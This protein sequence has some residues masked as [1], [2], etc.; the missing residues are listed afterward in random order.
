MSAAQSGSALARVGFGV[1][2]PRSL[3][4]VTQHRRR[5]RD[6]PAPPAESDGE[7]AKR[8]RPG[9]EQIIRFEKKNL[10]QP[11]LYYQKA[12]LLFYSACCC[13]FSSSIIRD[14]YHGNG[15]LFCLIFVFSLFSRARALFFF[16][17]IFFTASAAPGR[18]D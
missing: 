11:L 9:S 10:I 17:I 14:F 5:Y 12:H 8:G 16:L 7:Q 15:C 4:G 2:A 13:F 1:W 18:A 6:A 3:S